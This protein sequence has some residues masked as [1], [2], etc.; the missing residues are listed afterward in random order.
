MSHIYESFNGFLGL[1]SDLKRQLIHR[2]LQYRHFPTIFHQILPSLVQ[3]RQ[4]ALN[5]DSFLDSKDGVMMT[6]LTVSA[7]APS[8]GKSALDS[9]LIFSLRPYGLLKNEIRAGS[10]ES[11]ELTYLTT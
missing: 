7:A 6:S 9:I 5:N 4:Q 3:I 8:V 1:G 2:Q 10:M 11:N